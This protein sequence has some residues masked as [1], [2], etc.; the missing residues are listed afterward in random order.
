MTLR[1]RMKNTMYDR[2]DAYAYHIPEYNEYEGEIVPCPKWVSS[3]SFCLS[4]G[5]PQFPF[6]ILCKDDIICGWE[7]PNRQNNSIIIDDR[8]LVTKTATGYSCNCTGY[9]Y[10]RTCSH[11]IRLSQNQGDS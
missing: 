8:Y 7:L 9:H 3:D 4:T 6:R 11:V 2:R 5:D 10:R 1:I